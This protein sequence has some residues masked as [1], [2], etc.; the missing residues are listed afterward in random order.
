MSP[1]IDESIT[2]QDAI[3]RDDKQPL[4]ALKACYLLSGRF[5]I[6]DVASIQ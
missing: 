4:L 2:V 1:L 6:A 3:S 5:A